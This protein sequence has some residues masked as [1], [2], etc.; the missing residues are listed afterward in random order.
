MLETLKKLSRRRVIVICILGLLLASGSIYFCTTLLNPFATQIPDV[1][2]LVPEDVDWLIEIDDL[3]GFLKGVENTTFYSALDRNNG[4]QKCLR[5]PEVTGG[6]WLPSVRKGFKQLT[7]TTWNLPFG[8]ELSD[9]VGKQVVLAGH[10]NTADALGVALARPTDFKVRMA[11]NILLDETLT[12]LLA[13]DQLREEGARCVHHG[14]FT[15]IIAGQGEKEQVFG[16]TIIGDVVVVGTDVSMVS[17][18]RLD[19][20]RHGARFRP[21]SRFRP[22]NIW[23]GDDAT[24][25][26]ALY[27]RDNLDAAVGF[28]ENVL[29][30]LLGEGALPL[31][32]RFAPEVV[33]DDVYLKLRIG[34]DLQL[35]AS[36]EVQALSGSDQVSRMEEASASLMESTILPV[37]DLLPHYVWGLAWL[38]SKPGELAQFALNDPGLLDA[39]KRELWL[40]EMA[41]RLPRFRGLGS[42]AAVAN[43]VK[44]ELDSC[45][46]P[47]VAV[48][49]LRKDRD[50]GNLVPD[51]ETGFVLIVP[52]RDRGGLDEF[53]REVDASLDPS[54]P[55][56]ERFDFNAGK[57]T[58]W[59]IPTKGLVDDPAITQPGFGVIGDALVFTN[60]F[61][62]LAEGAAGVARRDQQGS[63]LGQQCVD[64]LRRQAESSFAPRFFLSL[65]NEQVHAFLDAAKEGWLQERGELQAY[66]EVGIRQRLV[67]EALRRN[68]PDSQREAWIASQFHVEAARMKGDPRVH[69][70]E[71]DRRLEYFRDALDTG[72]LGVHLEDERLT[73][74]L[75]L[76]PRHL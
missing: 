55:S 41:S 70:Q 72:F 61:R 11:V 17:R 18:M 59:R 5:G 38:G 31:L 36:F 69:R 15:E 40:D 57:M 62:A 47:D 56:L 27:R 23:D 74:T 76:T 68:I 20:E 16:L 34:E 75:R 49:F 48:A 3:P 30:P 35:R 45:L 29:M 58:F 39:D 25:I 66:E 54:A 53:I 13:A 52:I 28:E 71:M 6:N 65:D 9:I 4:F 21:L 64:D 8:L 33:G 2:V 46:G 14:H 73:L 51:G 42:P 7:G 26:S 10:G 43:Q 67:Q 60:W 19:F 24:S 63:A 32:N 22:G 37:V 50:A 12:D 44:R 1:L